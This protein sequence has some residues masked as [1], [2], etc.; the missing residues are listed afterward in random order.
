MI[1]IFKAEILKL[2]IE[3]MNY[4]P[5]HVVDIFIKLI[6]FFILF[7]KFSGDYSV[8]TYLYW[9]IGTNLITEL[10]MSMSQEKQTGT[11]DAIMISP[12]S[13]LK[14]LTIRSYTIFLYSIF[15]SMI[16]LGFIYIITKTAIPYLSF[17]IIMIFVISL[18][19]FTGLGIFLA[20]LTLRFAKVASFEQLL[21]YILLIASA[22][23]P[24]VDLKPFWVRILI[25]AFPFTNAQYLSYNFANNV[26]KLD[27]ICLFII[28][29]LLILGLGIVTF[30]KFMKSAKFKGI[31]NHY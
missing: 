13:T 5:D 25:K 21:M 23:I 12:Y 3:I 15:K 10:S 20:S 18:I 9:I 28:S 22:I 29:N 4:Y 27:E 1:K 11:V 6:F 31:A 2:K 26:I 8:I 19:G 24:E 30:N 14:I 7:R 17:N 16:L